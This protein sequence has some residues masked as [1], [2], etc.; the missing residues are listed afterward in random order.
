M[1]RYSSCRPRRRAENAHKGR[2]RVGARGL[3]TKAVGADTVTHGRDAVVQRIYL[4]KSRRKLGAVSLSRTAKMGT[5]HILSA[6]KHVAITC[7]SATAAISTVIA[8]LNIPD[9]ADRSPA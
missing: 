4:L 7:F 3:Q 6:A 8:N 2:G 1:D 9:S 5:P